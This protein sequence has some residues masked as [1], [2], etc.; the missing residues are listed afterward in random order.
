MTNNLVIYVN[1]VV[2]AIKMIY[3]FPMIVFFQKFWTI[4]KKLDNEQQLW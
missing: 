1:L 4:E 2:P 3:V